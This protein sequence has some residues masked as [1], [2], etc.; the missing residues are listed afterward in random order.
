MRFSTN[1][2]KHLAFINGDSEAAQ[3]ITAVS[4]KK[5]CYT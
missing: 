2:T 1:A 5:G 3:N 4:D